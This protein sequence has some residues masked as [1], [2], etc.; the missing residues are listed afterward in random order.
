MISTPL[1]LFSEPYFRNPILLNS[2]S[3]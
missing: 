1:T 2:G 3:W